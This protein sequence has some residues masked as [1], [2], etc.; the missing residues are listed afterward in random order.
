MFSAHT[1]PFPSPSILSRFA[2]LSLL[3]VSMIAFKTL[4]DYAKNTPKMYTRFISFFMDVEPLFWGAP[5]DKPL[6]AYW[7]RLVEVEMK[8][9]R[10]LKLASKSQEICASNECDYLPNFGWTID[11]MLSSVESCKYFRQRMSPPCLKY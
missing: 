2:R 8:S 11:N 3:S 9:S 10:H 1:S 6:N 4:V 7:N 5:R